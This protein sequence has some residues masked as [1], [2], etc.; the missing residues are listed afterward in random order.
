MSR[1][2]NLTDQ[3]GRRFGLTTLYVRLGNAPSLKRR[4]ANAILTSGLTS[5]KTG[6]QFFLGEGPNF[7]KVNPSL[8]PP[9]RWGGLRGL[10]A[11]AAG[12]LAA[13]S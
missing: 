12:D 6:G 4:L 8:I 9:I 2:D 7:W 11:L 1:T 5:V 13:N 10:E 3:H